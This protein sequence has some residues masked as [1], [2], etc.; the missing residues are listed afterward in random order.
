[1]TMSQ[2]EE[3]A[4]CQSEFYS[5][6]YFLLLVYWLYY[7]EIVVYLLCIPTYSKKVEIVREAYGYYIPTVPEFLIEACSI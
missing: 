4:L 7:F 6:S 2:V 5:P 3:L 1:M